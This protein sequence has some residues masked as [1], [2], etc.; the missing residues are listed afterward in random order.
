MREK[1]PSEKGFNKFWKLKICL[2]ENSLYFRCSF[3]EN[4]K[5]RKRTRRKYEIKIKRK[6]RRRNF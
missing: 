5:K 1:I 6:D 2:Q 3:R 4:V